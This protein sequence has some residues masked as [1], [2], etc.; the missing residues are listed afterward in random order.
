MYQLTMG[1][2]YNH[3]CISRSIFYSRWDTGD[4]KICGM[5]FEGFEMHK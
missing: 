2:V 1:I 5:E 3:F 4:G